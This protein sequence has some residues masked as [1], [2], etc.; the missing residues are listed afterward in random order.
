MSSR[1]DL[2]KS[3][4]LL[5]SML[6]SN[7]LLVSMLCGDDDEEGGGLRDQNDK[8][9]VGG[10]GGWATVLSEGGIGSLMTR[11]CDNVDDVEGNEEHT[12]VLSSLVISFS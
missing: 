6:C 8:I 7:D 2:G 11:L 9:C 12:E 3:N 10:G 5:V 1:Y 4:D